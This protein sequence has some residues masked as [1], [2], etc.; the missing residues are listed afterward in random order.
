MN[1]DLCV[2]IY[3][4]KS[5]FDSF[6]FHL[7]VIA[8]VVNVWYRSICNF[9]RLFIHLLQCNLQVKGL[10]IEWSICWMITT[11]NEFSIFNHN[12]TTTFSFNSTSLS[13][14]PTSH[15]YFSHSAIF[16]MHQNSLYASKIVS[17]CIL[18]P[19]AIVFVYSYYYYQHHRILHSCI[20]FKSGFYSLGWRIPYAICDIGRCVVAYITNESTRKHN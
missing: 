10:K 1:I 14:F 4:M 12:P 3:N 6:F 8:Y 18:Q 13:I 9:L 11:S 7:S 16:T 17:S 19:T 2:H 15:L 20:F 5:T